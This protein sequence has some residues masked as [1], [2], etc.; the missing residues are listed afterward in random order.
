MQQKP[1]AECELATLRF[2]VGI[3]AF[4]GHSIVKFKTANQEREGR[5]LWH[6]TKN[7]TRDVA[8]AE[9]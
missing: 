6:A 9:L 1:L 7:Q 2:M 3:F 5:G 4:V 8:A